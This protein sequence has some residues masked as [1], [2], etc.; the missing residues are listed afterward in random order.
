MQSR[1]SATYF[2]ARNR[3]RRIGRGARGASAWRQATGRRGPPKTG[4]IVSLTLAMPATSPPHR[5]TLPSRAPNPTPRP[6]PRHIE[7]PLLNFTL[8]NNNDDEHA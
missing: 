6:A 4:R 5:K 3:R 2:A 7:F 1:I 8:K